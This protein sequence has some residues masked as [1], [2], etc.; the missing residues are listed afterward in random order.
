VNKDCGNRESK[1]SSLKSNPQTHPSKLDKFGSE[2]AV[3]G[4]LKEEI[5]TFH[6]GAM[7]AKYGKVGF[8]RGTVVNHHGSFTPARSR[9]V[10]EKRTDP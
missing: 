6:F 1:K 9:L 3:V 5:W 10:L 8:V 4:N 2:E 7:I